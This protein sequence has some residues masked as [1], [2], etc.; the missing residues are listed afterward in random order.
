[1]PLVRVEFCRCITL[2]SDTKRSGDKHFAAFLC[3]LKNHGL[4]SYVNVWRKLPCRRLRD[5]ARDWLGGACIIARSMLE[6]H[7]RCTLNEQ[8]L[9]VLWPLLGVLWSVNNF[10]CRFSGVWTRS[11]PRGSTF[12]QSTGW[13]VTANTWELWMIFMRKTTLNLWLSGRR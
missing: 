8:E 9:G 13:L 6:S 7:C 1:M 5:Y 4:K 10:F 3:L 11:S 2:P 12:L